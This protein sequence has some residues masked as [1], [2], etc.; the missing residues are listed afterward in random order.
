MPWKESTLMSERQA[1]I[2]QALQ[3]G[4]NVSQLCRV[5]GISRKTGYK[6]L[7]R[8]ADKGKAGLADRSRRPQHS[9]RQSQAELERLVVSARQQFPSWGGRK[10]K[11]YLENQG[12]QDVPAASTITAIL[13]RHGYLDETESAKRR[14]WQRFEREQPN[15]LWQMDFK[16]DFDCG[17]GSHCYPLTILD[18]RSRYLL[19]VFACANQQRETVKGHLTSVFRQYG[20][21][22]C[23]LTDNGPPWGTETPPYQPRRTYTRLGV[24]LL[25]LGISITHGRPAHPQ[26]QG[27]LE[28]LHRS[29]NEEVLQRSSLAHLAHCQSAFDAWRTI[30]NTLRPHEAHQLNVPADYYTPSPRPFPDLV[31]DIDYPSADQ[32]RRVQKDGVISFRGRRWRVGKAFAGHPVALRHDPL[33]DGVFAVYFCQTIIHSLDI[34]AL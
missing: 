32:V 2:A 20:L 11:R 15:E 22:Q 3:P 34:R 1:F 14:A 27:K 33:Q 31:P 28:R 9:P 21:P 30:Y 29:L 12:Q 6:W 13:R 4:A 16:G 18:D 5:Y 17:D 10:L 24:W 26:T 19:G 7:A 8:F 25:R 23:I